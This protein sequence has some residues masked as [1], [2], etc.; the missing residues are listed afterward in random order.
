[1]SELSFTD[2][3][4]IHFI[5]KAHANRTP[6]AP[7][8]HWTPFSGDHK[9]Y[10]YKAF[11]NQVL[12]LAS[13]LSARGI[14]KGDFLILHS[15]NSPE[16]LLTW[17]ACA[18][19]GAVI[20]TTNPRSSLDELRY[21]VEHAKPRAVITQPAFL[22]LFKQIDAKLEW[23][24][25]TRTDSGEP[26]DK[27]PKNII[28]FEDLLGDAYDFK[29][30]TLDSM[31][32]LSVQYTSGTTSRPKGVVWTHANALWAG[33]VGASHKM[34]GADD[35]AIVITPLCHTNAMSW[36]HLPVLWSGGALALQPKFSAS[37]FWDVAVKY[38]C[39]WGNVIPFAVHAL[40]TKPVPDNHKMRFWIVGAANVGPVEDMFGVSF[41]GAW[42][43]TETV[44][45]ATYTPPHLPSPP[46][47]MGMPMPQY[48]FKVVDGNNELAEVGEVG[49]LKVKGRRGVSLF[50]EYLHNPDATKASFDADGW[51]DTGDRV[52]RYEQGHFRFSDRS[53]DML[54]V[55]AENVAAS[56]IEAV[57]NSVEDVMET[58]VVAKP[59]KMKDEVPIAF[60][61]TVKPSDNL[62]AEIFSVCESK[63]SDFKRPV[64][65]IFC[66][67]FP[68][69]EVN[70]VAKG[71]LREQAKKLKL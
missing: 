4:D 38:G 43:M 44:I 23:I 12:S 10:S 20:V 15:N 60:V 62:R 11:Y 70:K 67:D 19:I 21:F 5:L 29:E 68:R 40:A 61:R 13:G 42:G 3:K 35:T 58:A 57:I 53:K 2:G 50:L 39:T 48:A 28:P 69:A 32:P 59:D 6:D 7:F 37:R 26:A 17:H 8:L 65:I 30:A 55:G 33:Q 34:I 47:S 1:M 25:S 54:K 46:I 36:A 45:H 64:A 27:L 18:A 49:N 24:A 63:L 66:E 52:I 22:D 31:T 41:I 14:G 9:T 71:K 16:F 51:F 56:E